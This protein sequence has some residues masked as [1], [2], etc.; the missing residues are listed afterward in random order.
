[1]G[2]DGANL[3][4]VLVS[5]KL[6]GSPDKFKIRILLATL[7]I[8]LGGGQSSEVGT[9]WTWVMSEKGSKA[10]SESEGRPCGISSSI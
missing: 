2:E 4:K 7:E 10:W 3:T 9:R 5:F 1:M 8:M 6:N